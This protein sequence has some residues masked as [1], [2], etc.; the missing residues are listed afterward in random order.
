MNGSYADTAA[1][2]V[3]VTQAAP[4][5]SL[6]RAGMRRRATSH[7]LLDIGHLL[8]R[9]TTFRGLTI[10]PGPDGGQA[11]ISGRCRIATNLAAITTA[12]D[13]A[14]GV[15]GGRGRAMRLRGSVD[16]SQIEDRRGSRRGVAIGGGGL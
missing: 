15:A 8:A 13:G 14:G 12:Y 3:D 16:T 9:S 11:F 10:A 7:V 5:I 2:C 4:S 6:P 1:V